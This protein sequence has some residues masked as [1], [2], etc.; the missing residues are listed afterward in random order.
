MI[1]ETVSHYR[2]LDKLGEGGMGV[3]YLAEDI[4]L[5]RRVAIK[6]LSIGSGTNNQHYRKRFLR[7]AQ[8]ASK[9]SHPHIATVYDFGETTGGEPYIVMEFVQGKT[10]CELIR[11]KSLTI[12]R[13][14]QIIGEIAEALSEAHSH[15]LVHR[16]IKPSNIVVNERGS[17][18]VLDFGLAKEVA[19]TAEDTRTREGMIVGTPMYFSPEQ[20]LGLE[21]DARSDL[22]SLGLVFYECVTGEPAFAGKTDIEICAKII[23]DDPAPPSKL[24]PDVS[25][26]LDQVISKALAKNSELRYQSAKDLAEAITLTGSSDTR[27]T[28][29]AKRLLSN[30]SQAFLKAVALRVAR[31]GLIVLLAI[32][33]VYFLSTLQRSRAPS[34]QMNFVRVAMSG[35]VKEAAISPDGKYIGVIIDEFGKQSLWIKNS[36]TPNELNI[37]KPSEEQYS[38]LTFS[39][40]GNYLYY[41]VE[42]GDTATLYRIG[43][44]GGTP[45]KLLSQVDT[46]VTFSPDGDRLAFVRL[47]LTDKSTSLVIARADG[48]QPVNL[49]TLNRPQALK[50]HGFYSSGPAW[51]PDGNVIAVPAQN[52]S[53]SS[54]MDVLAVEVKDGTF[55]A[56]NKQSWSLIEKL[57]WRPD[58]TGLIMNAIQKDPSR[59]QLWRLSYPAG[60][61]SQL[62]ND[63]NSYVNLSA[64]TN[65]SSILVTKLERLSSTWIVDLKSGSIPKQIPS[66]KDIAGTG[67][68]W[69]PEGN[70]IHS[71]TNAGSQNL[72]MTAADGTGSQQLTFGNRTNVEPVVS[73]DG[74]Y[75]IYVSYTDDRPHLWKMDRS[76]SNISQLTSGEYE[77]LPRITPD[78][79]WVIYHSIDEGKYNLR[80]I[81]IDGGESFVLTSHPSTQPD[82]SPDGKFIACFSRAQPADS[83]WNIVILPI[84]GGPPV[85]TLSKPSNVD[86]EWPA[87][88]WAP[89]GS[90]ITYV[91]T[92]G[93]VSNL[94]SKPLNGAPAKQLTQ[95]TDGQIFAF[96][97]SLRSGLI[98]CIRGT[99]KRELLLLKNSF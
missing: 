58:G 68:A 91:E 84:D 86:P 26:E 23:R 72:W 2:I 76:N 89:D 38:A 51:S 79:K 10:L 54:P 74:R 29:K 37:L 40:N 34:E 16:D 57:I 20:A 73:P 5:G 71:S 12:T 36:E 24:N 31:L 82:I 19:P 69:T 7:E 30:G 17:V 28:R 75:L 50:S 1:G 99:I 63:P 42:E 92:S 13:T 8:A 43:V 39:P 98:A 67:I 33:L 70:L 80:K 97:Q 96:D 59:L 27:S 88:R 93:G 62:T 41:L 32:A 52:I 83:P 9:L 87:I 64:T 45:E 65:F 6:T 25:V 3:V 46:P 47:Q 53:G 14:T 21:V 4:V 44:L 60:D 15:G 81:S 18:K 66:T 85:K 56:I 61:S 11:E 48:S 22:F 55:H 49:L 78:G 77:D 95:F 35:N 94:W 90:A